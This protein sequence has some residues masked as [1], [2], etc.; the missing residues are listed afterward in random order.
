MKTGMNTGQT[1]SDPMQDKWL[2]T[3][4]AG[5]VLWPAAHLVNF[6]YIKSEHR[7]LYVNVVNLFWYVL[8]SPLIARA[9]T[10]H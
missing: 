8:L 10:A 5:Y 1:P 9:L 7:L 6:K 3:V 4:L 2:T